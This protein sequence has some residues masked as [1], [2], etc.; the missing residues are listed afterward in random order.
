MP[1]SARAGD[2]GT[3]PARKAERGAARK[4]EQKVPAKSPPSRLQTHAQSPRTKAAR[5][6]SYGHKTPHPSGKST[7]EQAID[8][9]LSFEEDRTDEVRTEEFR[10]DEDGT[11]DGQ[12]GRSRSEEHRCLQDTLRLVK[13]RR[14]WLAQK[15]PSMSLAPRG[16]CTG[17][18][19]PQRSRKHASEDCSSPWP[20]ADITCSPIDCGPA[21][22][23]PTSTSYWWAHRAS[24]SS[25][26]NRGEM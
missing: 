26:P 7:P 8:D 23:L 9:L 12:P 5:T 25:M 11:R 21:R 20:N 19:R 16:R 2:R 13:L 4:A 10:F 3:N 14:I 18:T 24:S 17:T 6:H 1:R 22:E 15:K